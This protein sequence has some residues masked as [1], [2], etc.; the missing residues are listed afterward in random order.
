MQV[1]A[2]G[3]GGGG[4]GTFSYSGEKKIRVIWQG[5]SRP[6]KEGIKKKQTT[7]SIYSLTVKRKGGEKIFLSRRRG[8]FEVLLDDEGMKGKKDC[9]CSKGFS[10]LHKKGGGKAVADCVVEKEKKGS[11]LT[12]L[13]LS[14]REDS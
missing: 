6:Y 1:G 14:A 10:S 9:P 5:S 8:G 11:W 12:H 7:F 13:P 2:V 4:G 3:M